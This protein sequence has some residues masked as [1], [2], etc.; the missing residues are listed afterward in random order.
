MY[1]EKFKV[2]TLC[3]SPI[4]KRYFDKISERLTTEGNVVLTLGSF[5]ISCD[6]VG[7]IKMTSDIQKIL[8]DT[9]KAKIEMSDEIFVINPYGH[10]TEEFVKSDIRYAQE[11]GKPIKYLVDPNLDYT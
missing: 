5:G 2:I 11:L 3:G 6:Q 8:N 4:F 7:F 9:Q 10:I 1:R